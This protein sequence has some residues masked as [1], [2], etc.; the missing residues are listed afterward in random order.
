MWGVP[1]S[2]MSDFDTSDP[3]SLHEF[4]R[5]LFDQDRLKA[6]EA[7]E[8]ALDELDTDDDTDFRFRCI[9]EGYGLAVLLWAGYKREVQCHLEAEKT[10]PTRSRASK[11]APQPKPEKHEPDQPSSARLF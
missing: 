3:H 5:E 9:L 1:S 10:K 4:G 7:R 8:E 11:S 6:H 2:F